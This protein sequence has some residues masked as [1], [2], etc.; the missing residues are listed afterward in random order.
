MSLVI[1]P[2]KGCVFQVRRGGTRFFQLSPPLLGSKET[3]IVLDGPQSSDQDNVFAV[4]TLDSKQ[5]LYTFGEDLGNFSINGRV[6]LGPAVGGGGDG[7][8]RLHSYWSAN[9]LSKRMSP[10]SITMPGGGA[11]KIALTALMV[12]APDPQFHIQPF[13][14][15]GTLVKPPAGSGRG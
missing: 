8:N 5:F 9:R 12:G 10:I 7:L 6:L 15:S 4:S 1:I 11:S 3:P 14:L 2:S 13:V